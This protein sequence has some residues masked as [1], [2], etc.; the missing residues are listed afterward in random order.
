MHV[1]LCTLDKCCEHQRI[2]L[3]KRSLQ[4]VHV[5]LCMCSLFVQRWG[6]EDGGVQLV[7]ESTCWLAWGVISD[8]RKD[9][10]VVCVFSIW[11]ADGSVCGCMCVYTHIAHMGYLDVSPGVGVRHLED[12]KNPDGLNLGI[13]IF[14]YVYTVHMCMYMLGGGMRCWTNCFFL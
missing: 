7:Y 14:V 5:H 9:R 12:T 2:H 1:Q 6:N 13:Y 11:N 8:R 10:G 3:L 4:D